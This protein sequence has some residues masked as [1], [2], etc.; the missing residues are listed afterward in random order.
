MKRSEINALLRQAK[1]I[2]AEQRFQLPKWAYWSPAD[3]NNAGP[4]A[5]EIRD[6]M[7]GWDITDF[8]SGDFHKIGLL[9]FTIRNGSPAS[10]TGKTYAEKIMIVEPRQVTPMHFHWA[11]MED[12]INRGGGELVLKLYNSLPDE[13]LDHKDPARVAV[14]GIL[15]TVPPGGCVRLTPGESITLTR[16][17]YH[18]FWAEQGVCM[19]GE[20]SMV[21]DDRCDNR[22]YEPVGRFPQIEEDEPSLH[23]LGSDLI[24]R[25]Q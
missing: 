16:G 11:K 9:L 24:A 8:G 13:E 7:L 25:F 19:V 5:R 6:A 20:V 2:F 10:G 18:E 3:W 21:N 23:L 15:Q 4:D 12:I 14:D 1:Q 22:F 17:L